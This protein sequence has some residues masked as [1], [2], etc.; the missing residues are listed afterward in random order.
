MGDKIWK[1]ERPLTSYFSEP[2]DEP[3]ACSGRAHVTAGVSNDL[4]GVMSR[5]SFC[6][7]AH[8]TTESTKDCVFIAAA[9]REGYP[10]R[11]LLIPV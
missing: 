9:L 7:G 11:Y 8:Y 4:N 5:L 3:S 2:V 10:A 6:C 1:I